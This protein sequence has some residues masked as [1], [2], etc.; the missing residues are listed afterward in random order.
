MAVF[1][2]L[3]LFKKESFVPC[4]TGLQICKGWNLSKGSSQTKGELLNSKTR[5]KGKHT[6]GLVPA[7][8]ASDRR[9]AEQHGSGL[10]QK[11]QSR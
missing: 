5:L 10:G 3:Y 2:F 1:M 8:M 11:L 7:Y 6:K 9:G 4:L